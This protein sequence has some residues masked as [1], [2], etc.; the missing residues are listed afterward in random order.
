MAACAR[1][2][3]QSSPS[4]PFTLSST[5]HLHQTA[6]CCSLFLHAAVRVSS[7]FH[8]ESVL[9]VQVQCTECP[10][11]P[12]HLSSSSVLSNCIDLSSP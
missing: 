9:W 11:R 10:F 6:T 3:M 5:V 4:T 7:Q 2:S 1:S 12:A 8:L